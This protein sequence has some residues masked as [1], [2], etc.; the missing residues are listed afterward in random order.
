[1]P[2]LLALAELACDSLVDGLGHLCH[3]R[4]SSSDVKTALRTT[5][6]CITVLCHQTGW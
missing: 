6:R 4:C 2:E 3:V 1:M 5:N